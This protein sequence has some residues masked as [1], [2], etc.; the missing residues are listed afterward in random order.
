MNIH[1]SRI[2]LIG[3][4]VSLLLTG[5][6]GNA[7]CAIN[8]THFSADCGHG[9]LNGGTCREIPDAPEDNSCICPDGFTGQYC[10]VEILQRCG[11]EIYCYNGGDCAFAAD[12]SDNS[13]DCLDGYTGILCET[14][15]RCKSNNPCENGG[16]CDDE[17]CKCPSGVTGHLCETVL[18]ECGCHP[19]IEC[20]SD[21]SC[22]CCMTGET[23]EEPTTPSDDPGAAC[24]LS[25]TATGTL[26]FAM[27]AIVIN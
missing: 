1:C 19:D 12:P 20:P 15:M 17:V 25:I 5:V 2:F 8:A 21:T 3:I 6:S 26:L 24:R 27:L 23:C 18:A 13:C 16:T 14:D 9:C 7:E 4:A 10:D 22:P 11:G